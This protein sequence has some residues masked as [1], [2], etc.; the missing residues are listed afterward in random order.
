MSTCIKLIAAVVVWLVLLPAAALAASSSSPP[1]A[2]GPWR[3]S[4]IGGC[5]KSTLERHVERRTYKL[6]GHTFVEFRHVA[7]VLRWCPSSSTRPGYEVVVW[8]GVWG[9]ARR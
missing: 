9:P 2:P 1:P 6:S 3:A 4:T 8:R 5:Y 7:T